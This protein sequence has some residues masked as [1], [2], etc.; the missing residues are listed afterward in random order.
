MEKASCGEGPGRRGAGAVD[1]GMGA[2]QL[3]QPPAAAPPT[4]AAACR[5]RL[6]AR[7]WASRCQHA[8]AS[9]AGWLQL[10]PAVALRQAQPATHPPTLSLALSLGADR[11]VGRSTCSSCWAGP[12]RHGARV[13]SISAT[14]GTFSCA[15]AARNTSAGRRAAGRGGA[16]GRVGAR[17]A[18][19][20]GGLHPQ[21]CTWEPQPTTRGPPPLPPLAAP[22]PIL[23]HPRPCTAPPR[24]PPR[25]AAP[26]RPGTGLPC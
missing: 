15:T 16:E 24:A 2:R 9:S 3:S 14:A 8:A 7:W 13:A 20:G 18:Q 12:C 22:S 23:S 5:A 25:C 10:A 1:V 26:R 21:V 19:Q 11:L 6:N 4:G 17:R